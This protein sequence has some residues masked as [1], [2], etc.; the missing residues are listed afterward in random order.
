METVGGG[1]ACCGGFINDGNVSLCGI[2]V[3]WTIR[4]KRAGTCLGLLY[5]LAERLKKELRR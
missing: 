4:V 1:E 3:V 2:P 5:L